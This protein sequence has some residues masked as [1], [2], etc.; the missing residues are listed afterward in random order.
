MDAKGD[1]RAY[2][3]PSIQAGSQSSDVTLGQ[4]WCGSKWSG[5]ESLQTSSWHLAWGEACRA[6]VPRT[7]FGATPPGQA[8][9]LLCPSVSISSVKEGLGGG[10]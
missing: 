8:T 9:R 2:G 1:S 5:H 4:E 10:E 3:I 7:G 6:M